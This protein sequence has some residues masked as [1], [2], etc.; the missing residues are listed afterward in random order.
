[1]VLPKRNSCVCVC[2]CGC[3]CAC[4]YN[5]SKQTIFTMNLF[6]IL[7]IY[8]LKLPATDN[9]IVP[10]DNQVSGSFDFI[11]FSSIKF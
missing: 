1:M 4:C 11:I 5:L 2:V 6:N 9:F 8:S 7:Y 3:E 10:K